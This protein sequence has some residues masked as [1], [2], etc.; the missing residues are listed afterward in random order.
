MKVIWRHG[1]LRELVR[2]ASRPDWR[3]RAEESDR[4]AVP[5]PR[6]RGGRRRS[7]K[8]ERVAA[9]IRERGE[10]SA[11]ELSAALDYPPHIVQYY[12]RQLKNDGR[13]EATQEFAQ[14]RNQT[15]R[16]AP[17]DDGEG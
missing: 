14:A 2:E 8:G 1:G 12:L 16:L 9:V 5:I 6:Y 10:V 7:D 15:Y 11:Q 17:S 13:I 3:E 4:Q